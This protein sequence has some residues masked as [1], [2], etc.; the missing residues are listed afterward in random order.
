MVVWYCAKANTKP[1]FHSADDAEYCWYVTLSASAGLATN[2]SNA[3]NSGESFATIIPPSQAF[4]RP[5]RPKCPTRRP[6]FNLVG[7]TP[8]P[9]A[10]AAKVWHTL[11][12]PEK[13]ADG[14]DKLGDRRLRQISLA[15]AFADAL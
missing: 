10:A 4:S 6:V 11:T 12:D 5:A 3:H 7:A 15:T 8:S 9:S 2:T 14:L 13:A 1:R